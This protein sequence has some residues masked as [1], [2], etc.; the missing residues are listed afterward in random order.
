MKRLFITAMLSIA[1]GGSCISQPI[2]H[3]PRPCLRRRLPTSPPSPQSTIGAAS[4]S[5]S[6]AAGAGD[7]PVDCGNGRHIPRG[8]GFNQ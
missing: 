8:Y 5:A 3:S 4:M 1:A 7:K 2:C 6:T